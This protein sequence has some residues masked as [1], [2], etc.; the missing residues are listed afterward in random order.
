MNAVNGLGVQEVNAMNLG[1]TMVTG[2][3]GLAG[4]MCDELASIFVV[5]RTRFQRD[6]KISSLKRFSSYLYFAIPL[7]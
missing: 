6:K 2:W 7:K 4:L 3:F 1:D 5:G